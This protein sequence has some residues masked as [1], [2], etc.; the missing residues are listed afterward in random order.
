MKRWLWHFKELLN[1]KD[2]VKGNTNATARN[3]FEP[4]IMIGYIEIAVQISPTNKIP[5]PDKQVEV[6][7]TAA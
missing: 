1:L 7:K 2:E 6:I 5:G 4:N 3:E